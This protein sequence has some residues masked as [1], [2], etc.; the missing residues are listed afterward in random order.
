[1]SS[2]DTSQNELKLVIKAFG[3]FAAPCHTY[4]K[5]DDVLVMLSVVLQRAEQIYLR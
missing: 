4:M 5:Q 1:M 2:G 3:A